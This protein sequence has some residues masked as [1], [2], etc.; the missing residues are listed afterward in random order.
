MKTQIAAFHQSR[1]WFAVAMVVLVLV[2]GMEPV[3]VAY[4]SGA[5]QPTRQQSVPRFEPGSCTYDVQTAL[6]EGKD[7][8]C[9]ILIVPEFYEKPEGPT[10][11]LAVAIIKSRDP[12]PAPD[13]VVMLQGGPGGSTIDTYLQ[14]LS[15]DQRLRNLD[16]DIVLFD[17]RGTEFSKPSL[18]CQQYYDETIRNLD[19]KMGDVESNR[20][21]Q[22]AFQACHDQFVRQGIN[23]SAFN[24]LENAADV[25][26]LRQALGYQKINLY[27]VSY[28]TLLAL[29]VLRQ[30]PQGLR[31]VT[32]DSVVP[33]QVN[34]VLDAPHSQNRALE[35]VFTGCAQQADC[36]AAYPDLKKAFYDEVD[37]LN[38]NN[39]HI[40]LSD[41]KTGKVYPALLDGDSFLNEVV[42]QMLYL[43]DWVPFVPRVIYSARAGDYSFIEQVLS[44][45][46]FD[47]SLS[48]G[49]YFSVL[50]AEDADFKPQDYNLTGLPK[51][52]AAS[53][54]D[55]ARQFLQTCSF[56]NVQPLPPM[57]DQPVS[58][59]LPTLVLSGAFD[60]ITPPAYAEEAAKTLSRSYTFLFPI[61]GHGQVTSGECQ[62]QIFIEFLDHPDQKPDGSCINEQK[63]VFS[64]PGSL[65][66]LPGLIKLLNFQGATGVQLG[67]FAL[68]LL[69]LLTA[70]LVYPVV[71]LVRLFRR[72]ATRSVPAYPA[73]EGTYQPAAPAAVRCPVLYRLAPWFAGLCGL[74]LFIFTMVIAVTT[75]R[76]ALAN[77]S[78]ILLGLPGSMRPLFFVPVIIA[79]L[80]LLMLIAAGLA[81]ARRA[82]SGWGKVYLTLLTLA[83]WACVAI[84]GTWGMLTALFAG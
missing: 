69:F 65:V 13:P 58:S 53:E 31:S 42:I 5:A 63:M 79:V 14:F 64:T 61:G 76:M 25:D 72:P 2:I 43:T 29:H 9:G 60:P 54:K 22:A 84:L 78:R 47:R 56:W 71:W 20:N 11:Q 44:L 38:A 17:Q 15:I 36:N 7:L 37:R 55:G 12:N 32:I 68:G 50:C 73:E 83:A 6:V 41:P 23:L 59:D 8:R 21:D 82:G 18:F 26:A 75:V 66:R 3:L 30:Y 4:A 74:L 77:D 27:G 49:M 10:I 1:W 19:K 35:A 57:V 46:K 40:Q 70:L 51:E 28:G 81:W 62:D 39:A 16:R 80:A 34:F 52:L 24:S 45:V 48:L 33:P 67:I